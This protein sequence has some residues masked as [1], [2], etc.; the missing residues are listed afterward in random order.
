[1]T[2]WYEYDKRLRRVV[3]AIC[4][5]S[6]SEFFDG[7]ANRFR[8]RIVVKVFD[9][10]SH[11]NS[12]YWFHLRVNQLQ[13]LRSISGSDL[14]KLL[15]LLPV[16]FRV[17][18]PSVNELQ[19]LML[20]DFARESHLIDLVFVFIS[21][22]KKKFERR[23]HYFFVETTNMLRAIFFILVKVA[24]PPVSRGGSSCIQHKNGDHSDLRA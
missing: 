5:S 15:L 11:N 12:T 9:G 14:P 4:G 10:P 13:L 18:L 20:F 3:H 22:E 16:A 2:S 21:F 6:G 19:L 8:N 17:W 7:A 23:K 1:M 24:L